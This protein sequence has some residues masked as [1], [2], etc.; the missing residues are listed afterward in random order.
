MGWELRFMEW[1][2]GWWSSPLLDQAIPWITH[3]GSLLAV[4]VFITVSCIVIRKRSVIFTLIVL[5]GVLAGSVYGLK[6]L[7]AR[8]RPFQVLGMASALSQ[9]R[10]EVIDPSFPSAHSAYA[11]LMATLLAG[12][13]PKYHFIFYVIAGLISWTRIYLF[14]H[15]PSDVVAGG[16]L[17]YGVTRIVLHLVSKSSLCEEGL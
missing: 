13:F 17:G 9:T 10:G 12:W 11:F 1:G 2:K 3:L 4:L 8:P 7:I 15:Y 6:Y 5:Y 16:I 14:L